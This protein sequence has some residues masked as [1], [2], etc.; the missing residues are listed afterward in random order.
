MPGL[1]Q[2]WP[3]SSEAYYVAENIAYAPSTEVHRA[4]FTFQTR[5]GVEVHVYLPVYVERALATLAASPTF[6][7]FA[8]IDDPQ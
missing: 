8:G 3:T 5:E 2:P 1:P 4:E 7:K 6:G